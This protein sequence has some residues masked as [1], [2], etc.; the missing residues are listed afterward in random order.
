[1]QKLINYV[2]NYNEFTFDTDDEK[3]T[4]QLA[5]IQIQTIPQQL[6]FFVILVELAHLP[7]IHSLIH[8]QIKQLFELIFKFRNNI[9][10]WE[11]LRKEIYP[12]IVY[13]WFEWPIK[14]SMAN[15]QFEFADWYS[16]ALSH[17]EMCSLLN[18][19]NIIINDINSEGQMNLLSKYTCHKPSSYRPNEPWALQQALIYTYGMFI[20]KSI[21]VNNWATILDPTYSTLST[22][23]R[24]KMIHYA[25]YDCF[26]AIC[27]IRLVTLYWTFQQVKKI[28]I[29]DSFQ[30]L[31]SSSRANNNPTNTNINQQI[32]K[33]INDDIE[34]ISDDDEDDDDEITV[35]QCIK[36]TINNDVLY[37]EISNDD[38]KLNKALSLNNNESL[39]EAIS[40]DD[41]QPNPASPPYDNDLCVSNHSMVDDVS[42]YEQQQQSLTKKRQLYSRTRSAEA[43]KRRNRKRNL[44]F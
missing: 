34:L 14:T 38:N 42:D 23:K 13:Q 44:Y 19:R 26:A 30:A 22:S 32:I 27:L 21:T 1:M 18:R 8:L 16:W 28:N 43:R 33:N 39:Y 11:P 15:L 12:A 37:E 24:N 6:P 36:I 17:C 9:Y 31:P 4:K 29:L 10:S 20:D 5:L 2:R 35:N 7:P 3:T 40:D 41:N 25:I